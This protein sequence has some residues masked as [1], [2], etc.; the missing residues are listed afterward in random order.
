MVSDT[1]SARNALL[2]MCAELR[3]LGDN[4]ITV[5]VDPALGFVTLANDPALANHGILL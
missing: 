2:S 4:S 5:R 3:L 1:I